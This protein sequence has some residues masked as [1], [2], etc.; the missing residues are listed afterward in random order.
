MAWLEPPGHVES[1]DKTATKNIQALRKVCDDGQAAMFCTESEA[2]GH[3]WDTG[4][5]EAV[6]SKGNGNQGSKELS[7][8][9][10]TS[11]GKP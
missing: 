9:F 7:H 1:V 10:D 8:R 4:H 2:L 11:Y 3:T 5:G 6:S